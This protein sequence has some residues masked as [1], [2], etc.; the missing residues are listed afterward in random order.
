MSEKSNLVCRR[1]DESAKGFSCED[2]RLEGWCEHGG[3]GENWNNDWEWPTGQDPED[4][5]ARDVCCVC[6]GRGAGTTLAWIFDTILELHFYT[7]YQRLI[8]DHVIFR[9]FIGSENCLP[10]DDDACLQRSWGSDWNCKHFEQCEYRHF[11]VNEYRADTGRCCPKSCGDESAR[12]S[13]TCCSISG[14]TT[15]TQ[16]YGLA[17]RY[18]SG[19][20]KHNDTQAYK[21]WGIIGDKCKRIGDSVLRG[22]CLKLGISITVRITYSLNTTY[23]L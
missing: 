5:D 21:P 12:N 14:T 16:Q 13:Q 3:V 11:C 19:R 7:S 18:T 8:F 17:Q 22:Q 4:G 10:K 2:Y 1:C 6:G 20:C 23:I 15:C 9:T